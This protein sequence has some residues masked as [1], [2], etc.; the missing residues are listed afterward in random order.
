[1]CRSYWNQEYGQPILSQLLYHRRI[2]RASICCAPERRESFFCSIP[3]QS[4][5]PSFSNGLHEI[6]CV[7]TDI[8]PDMESTTTVHLALDLVRCHRI[9]S[10]LARS[11]APLIN[12]LKSPTG[13]LRGKSTA[14][15]SCTK[16]RYHPSKQ[17]TNVRPPAAC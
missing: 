13:R 3:S 1:M 14:A 11:L 15:S 7:L 8:Q 4:H 10:P 2:L 9:Y 6:V 5:F 12:R 17:V 16:N